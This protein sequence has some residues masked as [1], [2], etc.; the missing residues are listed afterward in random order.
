MLGLEPS[1]LYHR[2]HRG[3]EKSSV[4]RPQHLPPSTRTAPVLPRE[5]IDVDDADSAA[6][7]HV[8]ESGICPRDERK[9][10][11][12]QP[13]HA[14]LSLR[15]TGFWNQDGVFKSGVQR[16]HKRGEAIKG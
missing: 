16:E 11:V 15:N 14:S 12:P 2:R 7:D 1:L 9:K 3:R 6:E 13:L 5:K 10:Q 8:G 4:I